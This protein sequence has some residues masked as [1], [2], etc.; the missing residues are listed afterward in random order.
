MIKYAH[1]FRQL[2]FKPTYFSSTF[3]QIRLPINNNF[4]LSSPNRFFNSKI[5]VPKDNQKFDGSQIIYEEVKLKSTNEANE[6]NE[7]NEVNNENK[8]LKLQN[9]IDELK[10]ENEKLRKE[11]MD[12]LLKHE[13]ESP[14]IETYKAIAFVIVFAGSVFSFATHNWSL[15][16]SLVIILA[17]LLTR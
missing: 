16:T 2:N 3:N 11:M 10:Q 12:N 9:E 1:R 13:N 5:Y 4:L 6:V 8:L 7:V 14:R 17:M 15:A